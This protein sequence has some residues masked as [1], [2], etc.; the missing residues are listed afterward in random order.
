MTLQH[1]ERN[2]MHFKKMIGFMLIIASVLLLAAC[3]SDESASDNTSDISSDPPPANNNIGTQELTI[4]VRGETFIVDAPETWDNLTSS[5]LSN[6]EVT[7][8][9][10][11]S[12]PLEEPDAAESLLSSMGGEPVAEMDV[13][14]APNHTIYISIAGDDVDIFAVN[15]EVFFSFNVSTL[16]DAEFA[17]YQDEVEAMFSTF[18]PQ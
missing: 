13:V 14:E 3:G 17:T 6:L 16:G 10:L 4:N 12:L 7:I 18:R 1:N 15:D 8:I 11:L 5:S 2:D 9:S